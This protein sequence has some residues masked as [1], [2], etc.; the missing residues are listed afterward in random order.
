MLTDSTRQLATDLRTSMT[1]LVKKLR[2][3]SVTGQLLSLTERSVMAML[4]NKKMLPGELASAEK[5]TNQSMS[6]IL[7]HLQELGFINRETLDSDKRKV[8]ISLTDTGEKTLMRVRSERDEWLTK[9]IGETCSKED[10]HVL[11][12]AA[13]VLVKLVD[14]D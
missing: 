6:Q 12:Q 4:Q 14:F 8:L 10:Q 3:E 7:A 5:I 2:K 9:A 13:E 11:R 1:R